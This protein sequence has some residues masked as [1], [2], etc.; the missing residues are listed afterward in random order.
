MGNLVF[1]C[2]RGGSLVGSLGF[3]L[4]WSFWVVGGVSSG[5]FELDREIMIDVM[6]VRYCTYVDFLERSIICLKN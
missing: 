4:D 5:F 2:R 6:E 1:I 3:L